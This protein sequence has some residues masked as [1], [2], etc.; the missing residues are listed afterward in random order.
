MLCVDELGSSDPSDF[1]SMS[2][3]KDW[4]ESVNAVDE[5]GRWDAGADVMGVAC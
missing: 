4:A 3:E 1:E 2:E 5:L